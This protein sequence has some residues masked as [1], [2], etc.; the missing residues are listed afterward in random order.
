ML[1]ERLENRSGLLC[2]A[3]AALVLITAASAAAWP[4]WITGSAAATAHDKAIA[5]DLAYRAAIREADKSCYG[6]HGGVA[7]VKVSYD[8]SGSTGEWRAEVTI[9]ESCNNDPEGVD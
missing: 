3:I 4:M 1:P 2:G 6:A 7:E 8:Y 5:H 9:R